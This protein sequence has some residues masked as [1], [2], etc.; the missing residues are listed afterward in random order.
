MNESN[1]GD[2]QDQG[3]SGT[4]TSTSNTWSQ[5]KKSESPRN[6]E[7]QKQPPPKLS[8]N[9]KTEKRYADY[10]VRLREATGNPRAE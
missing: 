8:V 6:Q 5:N 9:E 2:T 10:Q 3:T 7:E 4:A 1:S